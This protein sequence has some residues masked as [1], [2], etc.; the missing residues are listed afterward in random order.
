MG[1]SQRILGFL[2]EYILLLDCGA[3]LQ[4]LG[5]IGLRTARKWLC[6]AEGRNLFQ[7]LTFIGLD[8]DDDDHDHDHDHADNND[9]NDNN[10]NDDKSS[11]SSSSGGGGGSSNNSSS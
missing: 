7:G 4:N 5:R 9:N 8:D 10:D 1:G 11:R 2:R 3:R 6:E